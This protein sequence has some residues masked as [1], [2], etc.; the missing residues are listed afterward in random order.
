MIR[1]AL[2]S[3]IVAGAAARTVEHAGEAAADAVR[4]AWSD[5]NAVG[6]AQAALEMLDVKAALTADKRVDAS[7][8]NVDTDH[9]TGYSD[10]RSA[11]SCILPEARLFRLSSSSPR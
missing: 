7:G 8:I 10:S 2:A 6:V 9:R 4:Q 11:R 3:G 5:T 1:E